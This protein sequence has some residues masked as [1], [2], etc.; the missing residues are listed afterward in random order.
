[1]RIL[2]LFC[3]A[4]GA[5]M[6]LH[7]A[8][9]EAEIIGVDIAPQPRYPFT[10]VQSNA[11]TCPIEGFDFIWASPPCQHYC[12]M[13]VMRNARKHPDLVGKVRERLAL[14]DRPYVIENVF[15]APLNDPLMLCGSHFGLTSNGFQ[16]RRH[17]YFESNWKLAGG[18]CCNH[19]QKTLGIYGDKVRDIAQ[20]KRH[21]TK[22]KATRGKPIGVVLPQKWGFE[23]MGIDWM[24]IKELS[25]AIPPVYSEYIGKQFLASLASG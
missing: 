20:E 24:N 1:M 9:P 4:G 8:F 7:R 16:L 6:G 21:Y 3:G 17:R 5:A 12:A 23:A 11:M 10:F 15:G 22:P 2:D 13:K 14:N 18:W 19:A 25:G